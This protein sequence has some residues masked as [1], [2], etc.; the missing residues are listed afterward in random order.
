MEAR[1][2]IHEGSAG[3]SG[4]S[5]AV[6][7]IR[8]SCTESYAHALSAVGHLVTAANPW[9]TSPHELLIIG[10]PDRAPNRA[11]GFWAR[12]GATLGGG[13]QAIEGC[14]AIDGNLRK[15]ALQPIATSAEFVRALSDRKRIRFRRAMLLLTRPEPVGGL[16]DSILAAPTTAGYRFPLELAVITASAGC[17]VLVQDETEQHKPCVVVYG[18]RS[19]LEMLEAGVD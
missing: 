4:A 2:R 11:V 12:Y 17:C 14:R 13:P 16:I 6:L 18:A 7:E 5:I 10:E 19:D 9:G 15:V 1:W 8:P 3:L